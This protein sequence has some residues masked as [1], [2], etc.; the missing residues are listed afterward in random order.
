MKRILALFTTAFVP[1]GGLTS[2]MMNYYRSMDKTNLSIDF[3][4]TNVIAP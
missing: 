3:A 1:T 4:S 2:V